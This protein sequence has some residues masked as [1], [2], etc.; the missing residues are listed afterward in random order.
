MTLNVPR[1]DS[2]LVGFRQCTT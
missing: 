1:L 2:P